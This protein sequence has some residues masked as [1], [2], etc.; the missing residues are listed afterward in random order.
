[1]QDLLIFRN[2][3]FFFDSRW[4]SIFQFPLTFYNID[5]FSMTAYIIYQKRYYSFS[6][7]TVYEMGNEK[8]TIRIS[9]KGNMTPVGDIRFF[10]PIVFNPFPKHARTSHVALAAWRRGL[11]NFR[12]NHTWWRFVS[13]SIFEIVI[14]CF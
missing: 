13:F 7:N 12:L 10:T 2:P 3:V 1:M 6:L 9:Q 8:L 5:V 14:F 11:N 4:V